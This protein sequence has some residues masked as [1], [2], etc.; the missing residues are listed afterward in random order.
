VGEKLDELSR[1]HQ[2]ICVTHLPQIASFASAHFKIVKLEN[3]GRTE[4][5]ILRLDSRG[6]VDEIA[7]MLAGAVVT[8]SARE[9]AKNLV[10]AKTTK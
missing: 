1:L 10:A 3:K 5:R 8:E 4:T 7:R 6:R 9:H 2:V